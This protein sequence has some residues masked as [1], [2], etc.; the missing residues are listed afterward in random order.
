MGQNLELEL[1]PIGSVVMFKDWEHPLMVYGRR[2]MDSE[3]KKTWDYVCCYFPHDNISSEYNFFLN[4]EDI[5]SVLHLGFINETELEFQK[6]FKKEI[7]E[8]Q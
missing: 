7:E 2:Q 1:L 3:T 8:K 5:S 4:H 6:L